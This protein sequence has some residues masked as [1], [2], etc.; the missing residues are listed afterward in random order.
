MAHAPDLPELTN[1][2]S[3]T[4]AQKTPDNQFFLI[5]RQFKKTG[6]L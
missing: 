6:N 3:A 2:S 1:F 4:L 5:V